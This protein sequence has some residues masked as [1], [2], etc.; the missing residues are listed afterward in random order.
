MYQLGC[1][2]AE[3]RKWAT[4]RALGNKYVMSRNKRSGGGHWQGGLSGTVTPQETQALYSFSSLSSGCWFSSPTLS[5]HGP[6]LESSHSY[7]YIHR[8][9]RG[10][11]GNQKTLFFCLSLSENKH[12][13][14]HLQETSL[15]FISLHQVKENRK[16]G[17]L[18]FSVTILGSRSVSKE[19]RKEERNGKNIC[20]L[21]YIILD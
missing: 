18:A 8:K 9:W 21:Y 19:G 12:F 3:S 11:P 6:K 1:S 4:Y 20:V 14:E 16:N 15:C 13:P 17:Y 10:K 5:S 7:R 2:V